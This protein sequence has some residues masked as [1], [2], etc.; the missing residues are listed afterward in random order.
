[1]AQA[2]RDRSMCH[3]ERVLFVIVVTESDERM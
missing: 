3:I 1:M 2:V